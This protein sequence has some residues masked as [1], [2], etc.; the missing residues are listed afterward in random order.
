MA[1]SSARK[2]TSGLFLLGGVFQFGEARLHRKITR[3]K[4]N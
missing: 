1:S 2:I 4:D 3:E